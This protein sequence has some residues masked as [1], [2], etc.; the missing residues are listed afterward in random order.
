MDAALRLHKHQ[1]KVV[2]CKESVVMTSYAMSRRVVCMPTV[3][4]CCPTGA[5]SYAMIAI[6]QQ[7]D[8]L[9]YSHPGKIKQR[10]GQDWT[11]DDEA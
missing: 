4:R 7:N 5:A 2:K 6:Q 9:T 1:L 11:S 8:T 10:L 3:G